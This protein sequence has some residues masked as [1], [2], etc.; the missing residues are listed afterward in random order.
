MKKTTFSGKDLIVSA[1]IL[2]LVLAALVALSSKIIDVWI[3]LFLILVALSLPLFKFV[4]GPYLMGSKI[5]QEREKLKLKRDVFD[6]EK[7]VKTQLVKHYKGLDGATKLLPDTMQIIQKQGIF[8]AHYDPTDKK[9]G[10]VHGEKSCD[11]PTGI[12]E[13]DLTSNK[14]VAFRAKET[15]VDWERMFYER[16]KRGY[17]L[18]TEEKRPNIILPEETERQLQRVAQAMED[19]EEKKDG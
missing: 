17:W 11:L 2:L 7:E 1:I 15:S 13:Y 12:V 3:F 16:A 18:L 6:I 14:I 9:R 8:I 19:E 4:V 10:A 5:Q